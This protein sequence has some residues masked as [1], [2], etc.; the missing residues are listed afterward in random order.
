MVATHIMFVA[1]NPVAVRVI[2]Q[3]VVSAVKAISNAET[4][5]MAVIEEETIEVDAALAFLIINPFISHDAEIAPADAC[6][7]ATTMPEKE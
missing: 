6:C 5:L 4:L 3:F 1:A 7:L 2:P